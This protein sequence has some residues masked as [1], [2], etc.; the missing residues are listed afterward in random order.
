MYRMEA[1]HC[2]KKSVI[3]QT[4]SGRQSL[5]FSVKS[6]MS[7]SVKLQKC[8]LK[9]EPNAQ[10]VSVNLQSFSVNLQYSLHNFCEILKQISDIIMVN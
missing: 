3:L 4:M 8:L 9:Y 2:F 5:L 1:V 7:N 10:N 6:V